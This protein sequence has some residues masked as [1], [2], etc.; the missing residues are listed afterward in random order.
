ML[1]EE[2]TDSGLEVAGLGLK[3]TPPHRVESGVY[4]KVRS[5]VINAVQPS[6]LL[7]NGNFFLHSM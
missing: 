7:L 2:S 5:Q 4:E 6:G 3:L 1:F